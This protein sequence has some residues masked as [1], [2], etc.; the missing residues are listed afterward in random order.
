MDNMEELFLRESEIREK[1]NPEQYLSSKLI[2]A[3]MMLGMGIDKAA[4][5]KALKIDI[6]YI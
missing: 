6:S 2:S 1:L 3:R 5:A 4:I